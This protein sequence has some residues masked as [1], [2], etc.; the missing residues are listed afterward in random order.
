MFIARCLLW[1]KWESVTCIHFFVV[2]IYPTLLLS[3]GKFDSLEKI[4]Y[5]SLPIHLD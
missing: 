2:Q 1:K 3:A 5:G 4:S